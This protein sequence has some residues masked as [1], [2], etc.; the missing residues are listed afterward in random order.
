[1]HDTNPECY[2]RLFFFLFSH[3]LRTVHDSET[4]FVL[5]YVSLAKLDHSPLKERGGQGY[6][7][8]G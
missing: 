1:M 5:L 8:P 6:S 2:I 7:W 3:D 4:G